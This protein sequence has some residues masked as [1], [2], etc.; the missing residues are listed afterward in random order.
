MRRAS[1]SLLALPFFVAACSGQ[2]HMQRLTDAQLDDTKHRIKGV[3]VYQPALFAEM[4]MKTALVVNGRAAGT[5]ADTP[6]AC[7]PLPFERVV[8]LPDLKSPYRVSYD[9]GLFETNKFGLALKNGMLSS[10]NGEAPVAPG[11]SSS[12]A[13]SLFSAPIPTPLGIPLSA[14]PGPYWGGA[15]GVRSAALQS[16]LPACNDGPVVVGYRRLTLP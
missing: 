7:T 8:V 11:S 13:G 5:S 16:T 6:A 12:G 9:P 15:P 14:E 10:V 4:S 1:W 2:V 3:I